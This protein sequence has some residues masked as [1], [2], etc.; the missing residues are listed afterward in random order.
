MNQ[1]HLAFHKFLR[2]LPVRMLLQGEKSGF[3]SCAQ[4]LP[5]NPGPETGQPGGGGTSQQPSSCTGPPPPAESSFSTSELLELFP[6]GCT[7]HM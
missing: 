1:E 6:E 2:Q 4:L 5:E 3:Y 7:E